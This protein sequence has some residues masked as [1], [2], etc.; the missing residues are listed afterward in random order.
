MPISADEIEHMYEM[1]H[2]KEI[3]LMKIRALPET[4]PLLLR[5]LNGMIEFW[6]SNKGGI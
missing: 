6:L 2:L 3:K 4:I 5:N 1:E